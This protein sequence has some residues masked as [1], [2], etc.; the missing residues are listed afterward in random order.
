MLQDPKEKLKKVA[1]KK[2]VRTK[3]CIYTADS[4]HSLHYTANHMIFGNNIQHTINS[5]LG[6]NRWHYGMVVSTVSSQQEGSGLKPRPTLGLLEPARS[7]RA[8][9]GLP[10]PQPIQE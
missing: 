4:S 5:S 7:P 9:A 10:S 1:G 8:R 2:D 3:K 6:D